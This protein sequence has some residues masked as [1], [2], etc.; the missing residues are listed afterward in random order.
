MVVVKSGWSTEYAKA[1]SSLYTLSNEYRE[2]DVQKLGHRGNLELYTAYSISLLN[3]ESVVID[4][5]H[6]S[7]SNQRL[8]LLV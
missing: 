7:G 1:H 5:H 8:N 6:L 2:T 4:K 3:K